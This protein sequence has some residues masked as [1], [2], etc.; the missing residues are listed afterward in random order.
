M[1]AFTRSLPFVGAKIAEMLLAVLSICSQEELVNS[2][3]DSE[4]EETNA[5]P[6]AAVRCRQIKSKIIAVGR[7]QR[8]SSCCRGK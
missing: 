2:E 5:S 8:C 1:D 6:D 4:D 7:M 3:S